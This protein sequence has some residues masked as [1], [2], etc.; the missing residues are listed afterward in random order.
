[1]AEKTDLA[2][3]V[4][5]YGDLSLTVN[6]LRSLDGCGASIYL[7][8]NGPEGPQGQ[9]QPD[10]GPGVRI[11]RTG[12]NLGFAGGMNAGIRQALSDGS[13]FI[14]IMNNDTEAEPGFA[15]KIM[16]KFLGREGGKVCFS[17][18]I[19]DASGDSVWFGGGRMSWIGARA[20]HFGF[21]SRQMP[22]EEAE[23]GFLTGCVL[24]FPG[25]AAEKTGLMKED[26]FLYWEDID[27]SARL[28]RKGFRLMVFPDVRV[29]HLGSASS[30]L[31][32][33]S[34]LYYYHRNQLIFLARNCPFILLPFAFGGVCLNLVRVC[35]AWLLRHGA[36]GRRKAK[37]SLRGFADFF[38]GRRG[39]M[40]FPAGAS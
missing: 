35:A 6:C 12:A 20:K 38:L 30:G 11:I 16:E 21:G 14:A 4:L 29:R 10:P 17:P 25:E 22:A 3:V 13:R 8:E 34:Y 23:S 33:D 26:Y 24:C 7:V 39:R 36:D 2:I 32:S 18:L 27:W 1:M 40:P 37:A 15:E 9:E 5:H 28:R 19:T 31:E